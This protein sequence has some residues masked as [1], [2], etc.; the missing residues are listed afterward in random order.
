MYVSKCFHSTDIYKNNVSMAQGEI[1][2][3]LGA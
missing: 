1:A 2:T 3:T